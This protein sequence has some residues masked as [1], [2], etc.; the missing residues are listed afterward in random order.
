MDQIE[1]AVAGIDE[2]SW[3]TEDT[4]SCEVRLGLV[5]YGGIS[6]AIYIYGVASVFFDAV[7]GRGVFKLIKALTDADIVVDVISGT[8]A[9]GINGILLAYCLANE[10]DFHEAAA[11]WREKGGIRELLRDPLQ[12]QSPRSV[13]RGNEYFLESLITAFGKLTNSP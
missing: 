5:M 12:D 13:L 7:R 2:K 8:S 4:R 11:I 9:G 6:L 3:S 1:S 10:L